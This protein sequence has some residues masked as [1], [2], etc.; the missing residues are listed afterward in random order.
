MKDVL[1]YEIQVQER[2]DDHGPTESC[3]LGYSSEQLGASSFNASAMDW[4]QAVMASQSRKSPTGA[5]RSLT[6]SFSTKLAL[7]RSITL[8]KTAVSRG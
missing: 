7:F 5:L 2:P 1:F 4:A 8:V 3:S 6:I